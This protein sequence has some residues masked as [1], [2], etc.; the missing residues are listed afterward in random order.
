M[1]QEYFECSCYSTEHTLK[2]IFDDDPDFPNLYVHVF[3][4]EEPWYRRI[5]KAIKYVFGY[6]CRYGHFD[7][8]VMRH[9]DCDRFISIVQKYKDSLSI[10][11]LLKRYQ[12]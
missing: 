5:L 8:F 12:T 1:Q 3:L 11:P 6:K 10:E 2:F 9:E 7:E 4:S